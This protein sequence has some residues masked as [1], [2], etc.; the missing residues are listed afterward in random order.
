MSLLNTLDEAVANVA[1]QPAVNALLALSARVLLSLMFIVAGYNKIGGFEG[2]AGYMESMGVPGSLLPLVILLELG[3][4]LALLIG[5]Q[6]RLVALALAV[7]CVVSAFIFHGGSD[8]MQ[9]I[10]FMKNLTM[11]GGFLL[12]VR[13]GAGPLA[14]DKA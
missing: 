6:A 8:Q 12:I 5:L 14:V 9:Q 11:A 4:G 7:F 10:L 3:G 13:T 1:R 2:T